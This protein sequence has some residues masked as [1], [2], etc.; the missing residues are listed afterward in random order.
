MTVKNVIQIKL[1]IMINVDVNVKIIIGP[2]MF[3]AG[4][5]LSIIDNSVVMCDEIIE[6]TKII[7]TKNISAEFS[8]TKN[9]TTNFNG[10]RCPVKWKIYIIYLSFP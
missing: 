8:S 9:N 7:T 5:L 6:T 2:K 1:G 4:I 10:K 3:I